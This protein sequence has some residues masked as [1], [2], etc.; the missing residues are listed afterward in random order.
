[1]AG[2]IGPP[3][4][5]IRNSSRREV[6]TNILHVEKRK[7]MSQIKDC[8]RNQHYQTYKAYCPESSAIELPYSTPSEI[9]LSQYGLVAVRST[10]Y[11]S[12]THTLLM[13]LHPMLEDLDCIDNFARL[14]LINFWL[15]IPL[16]PATKSV[17][18]WNHLNPQWAKTFQ[19]FGDCSPYKHPWCQVYGWYHACGDTHKPWRIT[20]VIVRWPD[21]GKLKL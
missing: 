8:T 12:I 4:C 13:I 15:R 6:Y 16:W 1:M 10:K 2:I 21:F 19:A 9:I 3:V 11:C 20:S 17:S 5:I 7:Y 14:L 18:E